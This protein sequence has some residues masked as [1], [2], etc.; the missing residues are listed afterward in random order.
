MIFLFLN[1]KYTRVK[2]GLNKDDN[3][4]YAVKILKKSLMSTSTERNVRNEINVL[5]ELNHPNIVNII[6]AFDNAEYLKKN[7]SM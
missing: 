3:K 6:E 2:L 4:Y 1:L 7:G 5:K